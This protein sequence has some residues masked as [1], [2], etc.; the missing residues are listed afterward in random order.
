MM[1]LRSAHTDKLRAAW[2]KGLGISLSDNFF[3][4]AHVPKNMEVRP[5]GDKCKIYNGIGYVLT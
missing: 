4:V 1:S 2:D 3:K 5:Y